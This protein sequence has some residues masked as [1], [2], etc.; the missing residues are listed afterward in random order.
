MDKNNPQLYTPEQVAKI[1]QVKAESVRRYV[2]SGQL[3]AIKL[4]GKFIRI[5]RRDLDK[6]IEQFKIRSI[7]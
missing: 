4:G 2:R 3:K 1:L 7:P 5:E 6:F